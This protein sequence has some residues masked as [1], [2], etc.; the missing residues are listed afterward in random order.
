MIST[1]TDV[2]N[3]NSN[4]TIV[5]LSA[6][7]YTTKT[8]SKHRFANRFVTYITEGHK[9]FYYFLHNLH[10]YKKT[11]LNESFTTRKNTN[12][13]IINIEIMSLS[14]QRAMV[15]TNVEVTNTNST[16]KQIFGNRPT[17]DAKFVRVN[18]FNKTS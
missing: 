12:M 4:I 15:I 6:S 9:Q 1:D 3:R 16:I 5:R 10:D 13:L 18:R 11:R 14:W 2:R 8:F 17:L 7:T